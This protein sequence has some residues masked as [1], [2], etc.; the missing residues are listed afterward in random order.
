MGKIKLKWVL[1]FML[2]PILS[3]ARLRVERTVLREALRYN[4][5][6]PGKFGASCRQ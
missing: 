3:H 6:Q 5:I 1:L 4:T 2:F